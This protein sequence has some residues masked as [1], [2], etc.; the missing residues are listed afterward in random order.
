MATRV[1]T[2]VA[3]AFIFMS[4]SSTGPVQ[5]PETGERFGKM[6][7]YRFRKEVIK[8]YGLF[9]LALFL[10]LVSFSIDLYAGIIAVDSP[11]AV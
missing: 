9:L 5:K 1:V 11:R 10:F 6:I 8:L 2:F 7:F 4:C 3:L